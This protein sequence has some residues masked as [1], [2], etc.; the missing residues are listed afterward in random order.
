MSIIIKVL[1]N[2]IFGPIPPS[3]ANVTIASHFRQ[4]FWYGISL[5]PLPKQFICKMKI[6][7]HF[8][9]QTFSTDKLV[10]TNEYFCVYNINMHNQT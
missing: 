5:F 9:L 6:F 1:S 7:I 4:V 10:A 8:L 2:Y 3:V